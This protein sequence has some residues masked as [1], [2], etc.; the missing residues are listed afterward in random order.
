MNARPT[1]LITGA[2]G[3][4][5]SHLAAHLCRA[6]Y[7]LFLMARSRNGRGALDRVRAR[8]VW[9]GLRDH[10]NI[11]IIEGVLD[12]PGLGLDA[13]ARRNV[14]N[15]VDMVLHCAADTSFA[16]RNRSRVE[17]ANVGAPH[18]LMDLL[19]GGRCRHFHHMSTAYVAGR[20]EGVV[21]EELHEPPGFYNVY[22]ETKCR[23]E[24]ELEVRCRNAR[25]ALSIYRPSIIYGD[26]RTGR[27]TQF[28]AI[29]FPVRTLLHIR[30]VLVKDLEEGDG[31][32]A[33]SY[34]ASLTSDGRLF[35]PIRFEN[36][37]SGTID[38]IPID[39]LVRS[40]GAIMEKADAAGIFHIVNRKSCTLG[41]LMEYTRR[42]YPIR[43]L[44][45][46]EWKAF[47]VEPRNS[48]ERLFHKHLA[49]YDVYMQDQRRFD[50]SRARE[51][52]DPAGLTC[53]DFTFESFRRCM[54][55]AQS[56]E[57]GRAL[58]TE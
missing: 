30:S 27:S 6:G 15:S 47:E 31:E 20:T 58:W 35:M 26:S 42:L 56:V 28:G 40:V 13:E 54:D 48:L 32:R 16:E 5:G 4:V 53:P 19:E 39:H 14:I 29:Y 41:E 51:I 21:L 3:F 9:A 18:L 24:R 34:G 12:T 23:A 17:T 43:G 7:P 37:A 38:L 45:L 10:R 22:E 25:M 33:Q 1:V 8:L 57:W 44:S 11:T 55:F 52:L 49:L 2:T 50:D 36:H 46:A